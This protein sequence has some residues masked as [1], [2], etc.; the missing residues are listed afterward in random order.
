MKKIS[1]KEKVCKMMN[2]MIA[3]TQMELIRQYNEYDENKLL[4]WVIC[5]VFS[6]FSLIKLNM[7]IIT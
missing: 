1:M 2:M 7:Y 3:L 5:N 4:F 6:L